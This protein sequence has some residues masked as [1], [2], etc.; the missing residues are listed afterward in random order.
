M[1]KVIEINHLLSISNTFATSVIL[2]FFIYYFRT[3]IKNGNVRQYE[4]GL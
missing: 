2:E 3:S 4:M 1:Y